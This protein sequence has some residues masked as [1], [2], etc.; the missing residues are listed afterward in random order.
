[1]TEIEIK[2]RVADPQAIERSIRGFAAFSGETVKNDAYW[3]LPAK[4]VNPLKV[5]I[6]EERD[7]AESTVNAIESRFETIVTYKK[8]ELRGD[9]EVNDEREFAISDRAAFETLIGDIG[10]TPQIKKEKRTKTF[11]CKTDDET[12]VTVELSLVAGLGWFVEIEILADNPTEEETAKAQTALRTIL[13]RCEIQ[14]SAIETRYYTDMLA[15]KAR[16]AS[17]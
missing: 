10:F 15:E 2:A 3:T 8:K 1:M 12:P 16:G 11:S 14:E 7:L 4:A 17:R 6:R 5:R 9:S 13:R